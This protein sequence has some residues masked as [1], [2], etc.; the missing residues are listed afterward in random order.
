MQSWIPF[1]PESASTESGKVDALYFYLSGV[2]VF[3]TLLIFPG[4]YFLCHS[5]SAAL[6][7]RSAAAD[8]R[9][10]QTGDALVGNSFR[11]RDELLCLGDPGLLSQFAATD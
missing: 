1:V 7:T 2:T 4:H 5:L 9:V 11:D 10:T 3:F 8:C 6:A